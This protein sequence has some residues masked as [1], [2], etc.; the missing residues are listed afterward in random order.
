M[1]KIREELQQFEQEV[2]GLRRDIHQHPEL[3]KQETRTSKI[4]ED[5]L[6]S[7]GI[8]TTRVYNTGIVGLL[9]GGK[10]GKTIL[11][12]ADMDALPVTEE[13]DVP[14]K[15][16]TDGVMHACGH[17]AHTAMLLVAA[18][19]LAAHKDELCGNVKF[20]FQP[21][22]EGASDTGAYNMVRLGVLENPKVDAS[23]SMHIWSQL[24]S[25]LFGLA[26]GPAWGEMYSF[27]IKVTGKSGHT[28]APH[29]AIDPILC[30]SAIVQSVQ[31]IQT[32]EISLR[33]TTVIMFGSI[34]GGDANNIIP[35]T[36]EMSGS[37]R[38]MYDGSD[39]LPNH[40]LKRFREMVE[41]VARVYHCKVDVDLDL[42]AYTVI[43]DPDF[44][45][46]MKQDV[47]SQITEP[48]NVVPFT[49]MVGEDVSAFINKSNIPGAM[50]YLGARSEEAGAIYPHHHSKFN[51]DEKNLIKGVE[52]FV[53]T[54]LAYL[55]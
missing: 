55:R 21:D 16:E 1:D 13:T 41:N 26:A 39:D 10:P 12:R 34:H 14:Y 43:N 42:G 19:A 33:D 35:E 50:M 53:R 31:A 48:S 4:V 3:G 37:L 15:S 18:R 2:I 8:E 24:D 9:K 45:D 44:V 11:F 40:P 22:E 20:V 30:A 38:Y 28:G 23:F 5:Y 6:N 25:G 29:E 7:L 49:S 54:A 27:K 46:F 52:V 17:D 47:L 36:V 51:I 32:R